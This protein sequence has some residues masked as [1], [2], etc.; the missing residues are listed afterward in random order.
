MA[1]LMTLRKHIKLKRIR[2]KEVSPTRIH[3]LNQKDRDR[4][5]C[6]LP[7]VGASPAEMPPGAP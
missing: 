1:I 7:E 3:E 2:S 5:N 6:G 4:I